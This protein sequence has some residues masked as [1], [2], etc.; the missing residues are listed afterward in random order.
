MPFVRKL[1][2]KLF[3]SDLVLAIYA[4]KKLDQQNVDFGQKLKVIKEKLNV[5][6]Q[7]VRLSDQKL[8]DYPETIDELGLVDDEPVLAFGKFKLHLGTINEIGQIG[9]L[10]KDSFDNQDFMLKVAKVNGV[11]RLDLVAGLSDYQEWI[12]TGT[13]TDPNRIPVKFP[14]DVESLPEPKDGE[15]F[16]LS[17]VDALKYLD[18]VIK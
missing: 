9:E 7:Q 15:M 5:A 16:Y 12:K 8:K 14:Q 11:V 13:K 1:A 2:L 17:P 6:Y 18:K 3:D 10:L 4:Q